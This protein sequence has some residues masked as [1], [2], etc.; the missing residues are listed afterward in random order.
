MNKKYYII[1]AIGT[2][3]VLASLGIFA[4]VKSNTL[5]ALE[6][7]PK[8]S[9]KT[10]QDTSDLDNL[11]EGRKSIAIEPRE[12]LVVAL[13]PQVSDRE[14][15]PAEPSAI[16]DSKYIEI[17]ISRQTLYCWEDGKIVNS[18]LVST[19]LGGT[20]PIGT[21]R[22]YSRTRAGLM[23]GPGYY[24]PNVQWINRFT[25][26]YS[27]HGTY[28]HNNFGHPMSHGCV[29]ASNANAAYVYGWAP[30][31]TKVVIHY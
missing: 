22:I 19:G 15:E 12:F 23:S 7:E 5:K 27:I 30:M 26:P 8:I 14:T 6:Y 3:V 10:V 20:T 17:N 9:T 24:L 11:V 2:I 21:F 28:W 31:G 1:T 25:G 16:D 13:L 29:N 18:F 4:L